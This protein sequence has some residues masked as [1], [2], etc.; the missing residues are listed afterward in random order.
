MAEINAQ[1]TGLESGNAAT[2]VYYCDYAQEYHQITSPV[3]KVD[4][5]WKV[6]QV[7]DMTIDCCE[8]AEIEKAAFSV[9]SELSRDCAITLRNR[10]K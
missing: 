4:R 2:V 3:R 1:L 5:Y 8:I 7:G 6:L 10:T 9:D